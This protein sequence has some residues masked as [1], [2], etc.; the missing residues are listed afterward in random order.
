LEK[1]YKETKQFNDVTIGT[2]SEN[3]TQPVTGSTRSLR[4]IVPLKHPLGPKSTRCTVEQRIVSY[5]PDDK[6]CVR[7]SVSTPDVPSGTSFQTK[8]TICLMRGASADD[9]ESTRVLVGCDVEFSKSSWLKGNF[10]NRNLLI[11]PL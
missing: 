8:I 11:F 10:K 3:A 6:L 1:F 4:F 5:E 2:W 7:E 9:A